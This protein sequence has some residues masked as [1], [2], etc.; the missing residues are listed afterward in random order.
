MDAKAWPIV[1]GMTT[2]GDKPADLKSEVGGTVSLTK[3]RPGSAITMPSDDGRWTKREKEGLTRER[4]RK[5]TDDL[6]SGF[7][8]M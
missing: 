2:N 8:K 7:A 1:V 5:A 4:A 6:M 3:L